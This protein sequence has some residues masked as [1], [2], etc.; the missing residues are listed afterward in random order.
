MEMVNS[1]EKPHAFVS[2][3][4]GL[5]TEQRPKERRKPSIT[6][7]IFEY[8]LCETLARE[9]VLP[10]YYQTRFS[11]V[12]N[13]DFDIV[14]YDPRRPVVLSA[15]VSLRERYKQADL[16]GMILRQ[17]YRGAESYLITLSAG[18]SRAVQSKIESGD[19]AGLTRCVLADSPDYDALL[20]ELKT[21][22]FSLSE[23]IEPLASGI[24][25]VGA[26][27]R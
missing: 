10:F 12:P 14:C 3:M 1:Y 27:A 26:R 18:E 11:M 6:G 23:A 19:V 5:Y 7:R 8:I 4:W 25:V 2:E 20:S 24:A 22:T 17:V 13:A 15:K 16:E 9:G 21:R